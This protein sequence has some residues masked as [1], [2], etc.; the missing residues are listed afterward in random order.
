MAIDWDEAVLAPS[1]SSDVFG[2]DVQPTYRPV[3]GGS[4]PIDA[5]F[6]EPFKLLVMQADGE[7]GI[8]TAKP[9]IGVRQAQFDAAHAANLTPATT[10]LKGDK[11]D[12]TIKGQ[13]VTFMVDDVQAD[14]KGFALLPLLLAA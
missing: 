1:M 3:A 7:P 2:E 8:A 14:G 6:D 13:V 12:I 10:W 4:F 5:V 11:V 9:Q